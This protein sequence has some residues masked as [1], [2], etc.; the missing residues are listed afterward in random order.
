MLDYISQ[1]LGQLEIIKSLPE[2]GVPPDQ[3]VNRSLDVLSAAIDYLAVHIRRESARLG[4][5]RYRSY[6]SLANL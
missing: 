6:F 5:I 2:A 4:I 3:L 1:Q